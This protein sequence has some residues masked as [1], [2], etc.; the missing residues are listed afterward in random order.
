MAISYG[1]PVMNGAGA[2]PSSAPLNSPISMGFPHAPQHVALSLANIVHGLLGGGG[3]AGFGPH[4]PIG[5]GLRLAP[6]PG[7][8]AS[9]NPA[10]AGVENF[11]QH[12]LG[13]GAPQQHGSLL[14][15]LNGEHA[16]SAIPHPGPVA[17]PEHVGSIGAPSIISTLLA[18]IHHLN[19]GA[20]H[21]GPGLPPRELAIH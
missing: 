3:I 19:G 10:A 8:P 18:A 20:P 16:P 5:N 9:P 13:Q 14:S 4:G 7:V 15:Y 6:E 17:A 21:P 2:V 12:F 1:A 11:F